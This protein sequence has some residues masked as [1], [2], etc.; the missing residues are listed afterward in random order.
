MH[1]LVKEK[2]QMELGLSPSVLLGFQAYDNQRNQVPLKEPLGGNRR[3][4]LEGFA[5]VHYWL[6]STVS[7]GLRFTYSV[8]PY[9]LREGAAVRYLDSGYF[10]NV[11]SLTASYKFLHR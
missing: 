4:G 8:L 7:I 6:H 3:F 11:L 9:A 2:A 1:Y 5:G 10:H